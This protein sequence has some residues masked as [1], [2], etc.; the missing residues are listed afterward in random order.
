MNSKSS[1]STSTII[2]KSGMFFLNFDKSWIVNY[3]SSLREKK[4]TSIICVANLHSL[5]W[6]TT[7]KA[8]KIRTTLKRRRIFKRASGNRC[9]HDAG[10][11]RPLEKHQ[12]Q[13]RRQQQS[14]VNTS[15]NKVELQKRKNPS[16]RQNEDYNSWMTDVQK[17]FLRDSHLQGGLLR[18]H[19][20]RDSEEARATSWDVILPVLRKEEC[21]KSPNLLEREFTCEDWSHCL[22]R[23]SFKSVTS[24]IFVQSE[25]HKRIIPPRMMNDAKIPYKSTIHP[26]RGSSTRSLICYRSW[27]GSRRRRT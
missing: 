20:R 2:E 26:H 13:Q 3:G 5:P 8:R 12:R 1:S 21:T 18:H 25:D 9:L 19:D 27:T 7:S 14:H 22:Y 6:N 17:T 15:E 24:A 10:K 16:R 4:K 11:T 23:R